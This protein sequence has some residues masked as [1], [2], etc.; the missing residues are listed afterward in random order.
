MYITDEMLFDHAAEARD[1]W[2]SILPNDDEIP[3]FQCSKSFERKMQKLI[4]EQRRTPKT[5][6]ILRYMKQTVAAVLAVAVISFCGLMTV[7]A[8]REKVIEIVIHVFNELTDYRFA[9]NSTDA[10]E[11]VLPEL[12]FEYIPDGMK[13]SDDRTTANN[14]RYI[15]YEDNTG[16]FFELTQRAVSA[17]G[18]YGTILDTE[19]AIYVVDIINGNEA[20]FN[21]KD[22]NSSIVW[23]FDN[24]IYRLYGNIEISALRTIAEKT[25]ILEN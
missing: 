5:N 20:F 14:R 15:L 19:D 4:K 1:I 17:D 22:G 16:R 23:T 9:S 12:S 3:E 8:Y 13:K 21:T 18:D 25:I 24:T 7:E 2:L 11:I 10:D 6:K